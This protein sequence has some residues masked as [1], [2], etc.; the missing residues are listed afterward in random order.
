MAIKSKLAEIYGDIKLHHVQTRE[1]G[2]T[3]GHEKYWLVTL[4]IPWD[5]VDANEFPIML[6]QELALDLNQAQ[7]E[8]DLK[9]K[10][11]RAPIGGESETASTSEE[12]AAA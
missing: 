7:L 2:E 10:P 4:K 1:G 8:L 6:G 9:S 12:K 11:T 5:S 3:T